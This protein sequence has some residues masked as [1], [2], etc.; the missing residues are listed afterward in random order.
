MHG[1]FLFAQVFCIRTNFFKILDFHIAPSFSR[2]IYCLVLQKIHQLNYQFKYRTSIGN[3]NNPG[4]LQILD[5]YTDSSNIAPV[6]TFTIVHKQ[7]VAFMKNSKRI[8]YEHFPTLSPAIVRF[9]AGAR[10]KYNL[11]Q[12]NNASNIQKKLIVN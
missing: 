2:I 8:S 7:I 6:F 1:R 9:L 5:K 4:Q 12:T 10:L 11:Y 3:S